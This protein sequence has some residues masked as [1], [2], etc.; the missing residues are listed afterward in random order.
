[1]PLHARGA[2]YYGDPGV[3]SMLKCEKNHDQI[4]NEL[5]SEISKDSTYGYQST[6]C[7]SCRTTITV[8]VRGIEW[9]ARFYPPKKGKERK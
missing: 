9:E 5:H 8:S 3:S 4:A 1:M 2:H 7:E 6:N